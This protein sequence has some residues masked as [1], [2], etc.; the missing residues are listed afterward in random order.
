M[1]TTR[2]YYMS[3]MSLVNAIIQLQNCVTA[4][5]QWFAENWLALNPDKSEEV[6][7]SM[8]Q[9]AKEF[10]VTSTIEASGST[11][12]LSSKIKLLGMTLDGNINFNDQV[13]NVWKA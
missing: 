11:V 13:K 5:H 8:C 6:L 10:S 1:P 2:N 4:L 3:K 7:F 12:A 9:H